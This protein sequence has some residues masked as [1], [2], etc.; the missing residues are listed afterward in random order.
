[1]AEIRVVADETFVFR[2]ESFGTGSPRRAA[3][4][5]LCHKFSCFMYTQCCVYSTATTDTAL[6]IR[7]HYSY[8]IVNQQGAGHR[9]RSAGL[10]ITLRGRRGQA[11][12]AGRG[13]AAA[14]PAPTVQP[15]HVAEDEPPRL[16]HKPPDIAWTRRFEDLPDP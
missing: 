12:D 2:C 1:M 14:A 3:A 10:L 8:S 13:M 9:L 5:C 4:C 6:S 11:A 15:P 16:A 7:R